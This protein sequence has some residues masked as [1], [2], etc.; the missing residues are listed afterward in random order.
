MCDVKSRIYVAGGGML[1]P[2]CGSD[3]LLPGETEQDTSINMNIEMGCVDCGSMWKEVYQLTKISDLVDQK[4]PIS[5]AEL[6]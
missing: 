5:A 6:S 3:Q 2:V 4:E 1:C